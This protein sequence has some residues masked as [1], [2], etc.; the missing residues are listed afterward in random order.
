MFTT[1]P[2]RPATIIAGTT[3][4]QQG[5]QGTSGS[6]LSADHLAEILGC[7]LELEEGGVPTRDLFEINLFGLID[8]QAD[9]SGE[10]FLDR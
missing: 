7:H 8:D 2:P 1:R 5:T 3:S 10:G 4:C 9:D 6:T